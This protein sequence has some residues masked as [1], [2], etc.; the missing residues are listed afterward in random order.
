MPRK[1]RVV[2]TSG[3]SADA[4]AG[5]NRE[6]ALRYIELAGRWG[7]DLVSNYPDWPMAR[8]KDNYGLEGLRDHCARATRVQDKHRT[9]GCHEPDQT[10]R[11]ART[12]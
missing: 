10:S 5:D 1:V 7:A 3:F 11:Q 8:V 9:V 2:T 12:E 6:K 4:P